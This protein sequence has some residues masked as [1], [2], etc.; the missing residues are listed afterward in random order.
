MLS[1]VS[2]NRPENE[3]ETPKTSPMKPQRP[4]RDDTFR[5]KYKEGRPR[6]EDEERAGV[7]ERESEPSSL[8]ELSKKSAPKKRSTVSKDNHEREHSPVGAT[9]K[10]RIA[11]KGKLKEDH[12]KNLDTE[13][14]SK[15]EQKISQKP[16]S[17]DDTF[18]ATEEETFAESQIE[19]A[20]FPQ[21]TEEAPVDRHSQKTTKAPVSEF[22]Q[23]IE[24]A[25][26]PQQPPQDGIVKKALDQAQSDAL[27]RQQQMMMRPQSQKLKKS[28]ESSF[29]PKETGSV[30][31]KDKTKSEGISE[32]TQ[33]QEKGDV[34]A[35]SASIQSVTF[36][37]EKAAQ[38][39]QGVARSTTIKDLAAQIIERIQVMRR[40]DQTS[41]M[42]T[43][44]H[45]PVLEGA[46]I[47]LTTSDHAKREFNISFA[48]LS[49][50][51]KSFLDRQLTE[52]SLTETLER[53][54]IIVH[55][56]TTSTQPENL[57]NVE[58]GKTFRDRQDK[59]QEQQQ[60]QQQ[61]KKEE[62]EEEEK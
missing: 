19:E 39:E 51:A 1:N 52:N 40:E 30:S 45:P 32:K 60:Q 49:P 42:I 9:P 57:L 31:K 5:S 21:E 35:V 56:L 34:T 61:K 44:R 12:L 43:L 55:T 7:E 15:T 6:K 3:P 11:Q 18:A 36:Q 16:Q 2:P 58:A 23:E 26:Q 28:E 14:G 48:N 29:E 33:G 20:H 4:P 17:E 37:T 10:E 53:K 46:T 22:P 24:E 54:G 25:P 41:T 27:N 50:E 13:E 62:F 8:F 59:Q 38:E 47:T